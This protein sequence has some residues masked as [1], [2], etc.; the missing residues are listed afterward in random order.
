M[1]NFIYFRNDSLPICLE[2]DS[3]RPH[4]LNPVHIPPLNTELIHSPGLQGTHNTPSPSLLVH[5]DEV[6]V[7]V[8]VIPLA[9]LLPLLDDVLAETIGLA[10]V[11][12]EDYVHR[13]CFIRSEP[14][15]C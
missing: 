5:M 13:G 2:R 4:T 6:A 3:I 8:I 11:L 12:A 10:L 7:V 15:G 1:D 9:P 14:S